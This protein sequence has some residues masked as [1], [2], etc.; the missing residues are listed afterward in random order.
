VTEYTSLEV[1]SRLAAQQYDNV[2]VQ[3]GHRERYAHNSESGGPD[4]EQYTWQCYCVTM[5]ATSGFSRSAQN[6][7][8]YGNQVEHACNGAWGFSHA[9]CATCRTLLCMKTTTTFTVLWCHC[10]S[11]PCRYRILQGNAWD[12]AAW[13]SAPEWGH[14]FVLMMEVL[15]NLPHDRCP[16]MRHKTLM[17]Q[18]S[19]P[20]CLML[21][22]WYL[23]SALNTFAAAL[24]GLSGCY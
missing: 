20:I 24:A 11:R 6:P 22:T 23:D 8:S 17:W 14:T 4:H 15:D 10:P 19:S 16:S 21:P 12:R 2:M 18:Q 9:T 3:A 7:A 1:S 13:G 5:T